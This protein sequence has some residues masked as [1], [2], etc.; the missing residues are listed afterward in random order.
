MRRLAHVTVII[1]LLAAGCGV[2]PAP[3]PMAAGGADEVTA[4]AGPAPLVRRQR[5]GT[6]PFRVGCDGDS[7]ASVL[8]DVPLRTPR[9]IDA[10]RVTVTVT[11]QFRTGEG[12][13]AVGVS[14]RNRNRGGTVRFRPGRLD[15]SSAPRTTT[16]LVFTRRLPA[17]GRA[18]EV[19]A[20]FSSDEQLRVTAHTIVVDALPAG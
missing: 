14:A 17:G 6:D 7:C 20:G 16:T 4:T 2:S 11:M 12:S 8:L 15:V 1:A 19:Y 3:G 18:Y 13:G 5:S 10:V 9:D